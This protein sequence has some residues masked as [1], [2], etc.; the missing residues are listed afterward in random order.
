MKF[1]ICQL[2]TL[3]TFASAASL[4]GSFNPPPFTEKAK[5]ARYML[6]NIGWGTLSTL[7]TQYDGAPFGNPQSL[8]DGPAGNST[9]IPYFYV[10]ELDASIVDIAAD[11]RCTL[12]L[13]EASS[14]YCTRKSYDPE[15]PRCARLV[16]TGTCAKV[17]NHAE[18][19]FAQAALFEQHPQ[20]ASWPPGHEWFVMRLDVHAI[21]L[22]NFFGGASHVEVGEFMNVRL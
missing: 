10:S 11:P 7:S 6:H 17:T 8:C 12:T 13:S 4:S 22:I 16:L 5:S 14:D 2:L 21:W 20:M 18:A 3:A 15:D 1:G 9:G 19:S